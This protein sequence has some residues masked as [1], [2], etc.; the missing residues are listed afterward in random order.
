MVECPECGAG[1]DVTK[2]G[3]WAHCASCNTVFEPGKEGSHY[4]G[5]GGGSG[6][7]EEETKTD[8]NEKEKG[9]EK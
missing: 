1:A 4:N 5:G 8:S 6:D 2:D 9:E 7:K 3:L